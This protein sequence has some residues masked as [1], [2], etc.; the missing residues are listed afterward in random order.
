MGTGWAKA[1]AG[2]HPDRSH[3]EQEMEAFV[4]P[5]ASAPSDIGLTWQPPAPTALGIAG[6]GSRAV[7]HFIGAVLGLHELDEMQSKDRDRITMLSHEPIELASVGQSRKR[8]SQMTL[9][10]AVKGSFARKL[11]PLP[12]ERQGD[13]LAALQGGHRPWRLLRLGKRGLAKIICHDV[14]CCQE[15]IQIDRE[16]S[17]FS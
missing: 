13:H 5:Q 9:G 14:Q 17:S 10:V 7:Q 2:N 15:S 1:K 6:H 3:R 12:E 11:H 4:P 8:C 16:Y